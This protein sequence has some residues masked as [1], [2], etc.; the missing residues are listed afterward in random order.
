VLLGEQLARVVVAGQLGGDVPAAWRRA[1]C[2]PGGH[3][4]LA[5]GAAWAVAE[6]TG[7]G[8]V[9]V[10]DP[11]VAGLRAQAAGRRSI[12]V[13]L[14]GAR[15]TASL[16]AGLPLIGLA[17]GAGLGASPVDFLLDT[18]LGRWCLVV[19]LGLEL[20]GLTW[21]ER[22]AE[23]ARRAWGAPPHGPQSWRRPRP[24]S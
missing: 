18:P 24:W 16:L 19:G 23:S 6:S 8:L 3:G 10:L 12:D 1:S 17:M 15:A 14:A 9:E 5:V 2:V 21:T 11:V 4:L 20:V 13:A 22:L 7:A